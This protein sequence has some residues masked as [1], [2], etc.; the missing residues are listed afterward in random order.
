M[1]RVLTL[2]IAV[3]MLAPH[4][5]ARADEPRW[6]VP[7]GGNL[8]FTE[9][10]PGD[11]IDRRGRIVWTSPES[12]LSF[13]VHVGASAVLELA[14]EAAVEEGT[15]EVEVRIGESVRTVSLKAGAAEA[16]PLGMLEV[17]EPGYVRVDLRGVS[18]DGPSFARP[19]A[20]I[21]VAE[22]STLPLAFVRTDG[23][24]RFYWGRRGPSV[25]L[26]YPLPR[27]K[28]IEW[29]YSEI[30]V[31]EGDDPIGSYF[32]ANGFRQGYFGIQVNSAT[33]RRVLFSVWS[34]FQTDNPAEIP[35]DQ[36]V[37]VLARGEGVRTGEFGNEGSG[38]QSFLVH[39]WRA[40]TTYRFLTRIRPDGD[41]NT[42]FTAW[43]AAVGDDWRL[44]ASFRRP[45]TD[46]WVAGFHS[47][48]ENFHTGSGDRFRR[49]WH[50]N[51]WV[52]DTDGEWHEI[53]DTRL[54]ADDIARRGYRLDFAGGA[55]GH[56]FFMSN[57]GFTNQHTPI[58]T[59]FRREPSPTGP[60]AID[61]EVLPRGAAPDSGRPE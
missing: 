44:I 14:L 38:G 27:G 25:H 61:L 4:S 48:L 58:G 15:S 43:F 51:Q 23:D 12:V 40:G 5:T 55:E 46:S 59:T 10:G 7:A 42:T 54:T 53:V 21:V 37:V 8:Y 32:M 16:T 2:L 41:G 26:S 28:T 30:T 39:P 31:P 9:A 24:N 47:F 33:E 3:V 50:G 36:R 20:L 60:P 17:K 1:N 57:G 29:C 35:E 52:R 22:D 11:R 56:R 45:Q 49:A 18:R 19:D 34:P 6:L 13:H